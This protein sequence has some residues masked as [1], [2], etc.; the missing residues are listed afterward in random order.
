MKGFIILIIAF[1]VP[2]LGFAVDK[3]GFFLEP[4]LTY[5]RGD[6]DVNYPDPIDDSDSD[7]NGFGAGLRLGFHVYESFFIGADGRYS[8]L[9]FEDSSLDQDT[10]AKAFNYGPTVGFQMPTLLGLRVWGT[11]ILGGE[12]DPDKDEGVDAKFE[13]GS[14]W[15]LGAGVKLGIVSLNLEYQ[16]MTFDETILEDAGVFSG[17][18]LNDVELDSKAWILSVSFPVSL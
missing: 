15:R 16:D 12:L 7:I 4:S 18:S 17:T 11:Y 13:D 10:D 1:A 2:T 3:G 14:G 6:G 9:N 8:L 5:Q